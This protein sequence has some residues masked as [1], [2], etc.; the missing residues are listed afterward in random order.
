[1]DPV[2]ETLCK[3]PGE[4]VEADLCLGFMEGG[5]FG[6]ELGEGRLDEDSDDEGMMIL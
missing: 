5:G 4:A 2:I 3:C 6:G 1:M